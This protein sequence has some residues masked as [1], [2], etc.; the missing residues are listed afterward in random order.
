MIRWRSTP[1]FLAT[2]VT[3]DAQSDSRDVKRDPSLATWV[4][5]P[6]EASSDLWA[7]ILI[8]ECVY[9]FYFLKFASLGVTQVI[10]HPTEETA[11]NSEFARR[12]YD[13]LTHGGSNLP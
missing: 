12:S 10:L 1:C 13:H 5:D 3:F 9:L 6:T 2:W 4:P 8:I 11:L 7:T